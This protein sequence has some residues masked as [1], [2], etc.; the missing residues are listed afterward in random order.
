MTRHFRT[1]LTLTIWLLAQTIFA[2]TGT[3]K[4]FVYADDSGEPV[5]FC[6][7][8]LKGTT[9][10]AMTERSGYF[11]ID[12]IPY[13]DYEIIINVFGYDTITEAV[14]VQNSAVMTKQFALRPSKI[15]LQTVQVTAEGQR[16]LTETRTSVISIDPKEMTKMPSIGGQ[17]DFAQYLQVL[18]GIISTGDQGG[19]LYIRGGTPIQNMVLLDGMPVFNPFHSIGLFSVFDSDI[20]GSADVYT[21]GFGAEF[22]GRVS[23]IMDIKTKDGN[24]KRTH[25]KI[26]ANTFGAKVLIEGPIVKMKDTRRVSLSYLLSGKGSYLEQSSK[27][28]YPYA[29]Q[30]GLPFNYLDI[31]GKL[32]LGTRS[33]TKWNIFGFNFADQVQ[34]SDI[35]QYKW[36]NFGVGTNFLIIPGATPMTIEGTLAYSKYKIGL[37][38]RAFRPRNSSIGGFSADLNFSYYFGK[39]VL[40]VGAELIGFKTT[41][42]FYNMMGIK[43]ATEDNTSDIGLFVKYKHNF[44]DILL[45]EPSFRLQYYASMNAASP[46]PRLALKYNI[47]KKIRLKLAGG[48]YSQNFVAATSDRDVVNLFY[49][50]LS[51]PSDLP[52]KFNG[53]EMKNNLQKAQHII[54]GLELDL[55]PY[56]TLNIEGYLKNFSSIVSLNRYKVFEDNEYYASKPDIQKIDYIFEKGMAYGGDLTAKFDYKNLYIWFVYSLGWVKRYDGVVTYAPHFDRRHNINLMVSYSCGERQSWQFDVRWNYGSGFPFTQN[57]GYYPHYMPTNGIGGDY[58]SANEE[59]TFLLADLNQARLPDYHRLDINIK[60]KFFI[61]ERHI[62]ELNA[63]AT[64]VYN[65][66][67]IFYVN[68]ITNKVIHQLPILYNFG[69]TWNF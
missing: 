63:G 10:G 64:N 47:T 26:D 38:D 53:K 34:Y 28:F 23:S 35:A 2:Q 12:K 5:S 69:L 21:G 17:P 49:G 8:Q 65:Y 56:T 37:D 19:Q 15:S 55:I 44:R 25:G 36:N 32:S 45:I 3:I 40:N 54:L 22:G 60:K 39:S 31:Y 68:R 67:N 59:L 51:S 66:K 13:G 1:I 33:G 58:V 6:L 41:Y 29:D 61:G 9:H 50:F 30:K 20:M 4:G 57:Q 46:E 18:P 7:V 16:V 27:L 48:L 62:I 11:I 14:S 52:D 24:R 43:T 42:D